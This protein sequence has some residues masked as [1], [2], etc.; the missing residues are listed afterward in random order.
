MSEQNVYEQLGVTKDASFEEI[1][2][3]K[4]RLSQQHKGDTKV[5]ESIE[6]AY[7]AIIME[8]LKMRQEGKIKVPEGIRFPE[9]S[10]EVLPSSNN[11]PTTNSPSWAQQ[12][13]DTPSRGDVLWP[14]AIFSILIILT[15]ISQEPSVLPLFIAFGLGATVYFL[16]RKEHRLGR[17]MILTLIALAV[18][19]GL[20]SALANSL[21]LQNGILNW[22]GQN[23]TQ[24]DFSTVVT[25]IILWLISSFLR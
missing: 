25:F 16:N 7:D 24:L 13:L 23:F 2:E 8:R 19:V 1:Q 10:F 6:S 12:L 11:T 5:L 4:K 17:S 21:D 20:G 14:A 18:G 15:I 22:T 3:A 9:R